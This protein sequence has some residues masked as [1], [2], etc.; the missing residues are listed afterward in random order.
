VAYAAVISRTE[1]DEGQGIIAAVIYQAAGGFNHLFFRQFADGTIK[2]SGLAEAAAAGA[3]ALYLNGSAIMDNF[4]IG[5]DRP[6]NGLEPLR[7]DTLNSVRSTAFGGT[8]G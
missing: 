8:Q 4:D 3:A 5:Y 1:G 7:Y 6:D 2:R